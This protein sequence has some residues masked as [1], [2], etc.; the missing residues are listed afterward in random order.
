M[1]VTASDVL[2]WAH[3]AALQDELDAR[4]VVSRAYYAAFHRCADWHANLPAPGT[5]LQPSAGAHERLI[6]QLAN[7]S[8]A[9]TPTQRTRSRDLSKALSALKGLRTTADYKLNRTVALSHAQNAC[10]EADIIFQQAI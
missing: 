3:T 6:S 10:R 1:S 2:Q 5:N 8:P 7:P 4:A 9:C